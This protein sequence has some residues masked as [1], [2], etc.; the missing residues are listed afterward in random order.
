MYSNLIFV[1]IIIKFLYVITI[2][3]K[4]WLKIKMLYLFYTITFKNTWFKLYFNINI[5][6]SN[7]INLFF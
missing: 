3:N 7:L 5:I 2:L 1:I 6:L 4:L